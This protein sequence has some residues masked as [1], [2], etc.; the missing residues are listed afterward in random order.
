M[1]KKLDIEKIC[2]LLEEYS[3]FLKER[4]K[5]STNKKITDDYFLTELLVR[6]Q[7]NIYGILS[8]LPK[9]A[10]NIEFKLPLSLIL[11]SINS[12]IL[13]IFYLN[14]F[15]SPQDK[16]LIGL[17]NEIMIFYKDY[18]RFIKDFG[19]EELNIVKNISPEWSEYINKL[20][21]TINKHFESYSDF[22]KEENG[23]C[24]FKSNSELRE[25]TP[26]FYFLD[27]KSKN[28]P[29]NFITERY[30]YDRIKSI[31]H[32]KFCG[33]AYLAFKY[34]SQYQHIS[35]A[36]IELLYLDRNQLD[37]KFLSLTI[38]NVLIST[39]LILKNLL[40]NGFSDCISRYLENL[41]NIVQ[42]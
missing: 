22:Y 41:K 21:N 11:R 6:F 8:I 34:Y 30:K 37:D 24:K 12:D 29:N 20:E 32:D 36:T 10:E 26:A 40:K 23:K 1:K 39:N 28:E 15:I 33:F 2:L 9:F 19:Q 38:E 5:D 42:S 31:S 14:S 4:I 16:E 17:K 27:L 18:I 7:F 3:E 13:T 35:S 25:T